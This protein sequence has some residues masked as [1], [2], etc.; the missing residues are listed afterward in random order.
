V[1][2]RA[3]AERIGAIFRAAL[4]AGGATLAALRALP[5]DAILDA[6]QRA[7]DESWRHVEG[8]AFQP[9]C[10]EGAAG[11]VL[12]RPPLAAVAAGQ[13]GDAALLAGT[14][15]DEWNLFALADQKLGALDDEGIVRRV[16]RAPPRG[17]GDAEAFAR[18][19]L[20]AYRAGRPDASARAVWL[21]LQTDRVF[22]IPA[23]RLL[24]AQRPHQ[25]RCFAYLFTWASPALDGALGSC[26]A[27]EVP[28]VF[29]KVGDPRA[30]QLVGEGPAARRLADEMMDAWLAFAR[31]A[32]P[33][34][35]AY[36]AAKRATMVLGR[37]RLL[38]SDPLGEERRVWEKMP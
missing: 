13:A 21:A 26:H 34:W 30:A 25:E 8:L 7:A 22:R 2:P 27:I 31:D 10:E 14:N 12:P 5:P 33:G 11:A 29:G 17:V 15:L 23:I 24:E 20:A 38:E 36:D 4:G 37:D 35:P 16:L 6:Q 9:V 28:F 32:D 3:G 18:R 1:S 19:A